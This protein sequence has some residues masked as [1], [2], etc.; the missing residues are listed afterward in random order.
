MLFKKDIWWPDRITDKD[1][2]F[3]TTR[4]YPSWALAGV[5][6]KRDVLIQAGGCVGLYPRRQAEDF[7]HVFTFEPDLENFECLQKNIAGIKNITAFNAALWLFPDSKVNFFPKGYSTGFIG[8]DGSS[9][10][11]KFPWVQTVSID[12]LVERLHLT[13]CD[14]IQLDIEGSELQ[15]LQGGIETLKK[16]KPVL[17][18][19]MDKKFREDWTQDPVHNFVVDL[20]YL[21]HCKVGKDYIYVHKA[22]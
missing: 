6:K 16:F 4:M 10:P 7:K 20:G 21:Q 18:L 3:V 17:Q 11:S 19:E 15:A 1:V 8:V 22:G 14:G 12:S 13:A 2:E 9:V 5:C